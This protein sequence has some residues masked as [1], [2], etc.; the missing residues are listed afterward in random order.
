M[1]EVFDGYAHYYDLLYREKDYAGESA[2]VASH[3]KRHAPRAA[4]ILELGCGTGAH[5]EQLARMGYAVHG[6]DQSEAMLAR[7]AARK[8][9]LGPEVAA[10]L[11]FGRGDARS[12]RIAEPYDAVI[13][14]FHVMSYQ[15]TNADLRAA[16]ATAAAH[17]QPGGLFLFDFWYG[18]A[19]LEQRPEVRVKR[20][21]DEI[22]KVTRIAEPVMRENE[23]VVDVNYTL[24]IEEK[25]SGN[26]RQVRETHRMR[27][28]FLQELA[29]LRG[30]A[31]EESASRTWMSEEALGPQSWAGFQILERIAC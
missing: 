31:F 10:R 12:V 22:I 14:L 28:L 30:A 25:S 7:A 4:R 9:A 26:V 19:V 24:F 23:G 6:V 20:L 18:P 3:L 2:Y 1:K 27:Y 15:T 5:A 11:S 16:F 17:L 29:L 13:S 8:S 21:E